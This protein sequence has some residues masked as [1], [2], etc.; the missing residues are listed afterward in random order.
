MRV[1]PF[2]ILLALLMACTYNPSYTGINCGPE[3]S[4]P[5]GY[6]C[7]QEHCYPEKDEP[8]D[9]VGP[10]G[11][12]GTDDAGADEIGAD[13]GG[14]GDDGGPG[15][16]G[17]GADEGGDTGCGGCPPGQYCDQ[18]AVPPECKRCEDPTHC[19][20]D[21]RPCA[22]GESCITR[23]GTFCC[24]PSCTEGNL[25]Q[26]VNC[27]GRDYVC[28]AFFGPLRYDW[29]AI[30]QDP[31]HWC[32]LSAEDGPILDD[33]RCYDSGN[34]QYYCPWDGI[35]SGGLCVHNPMVERTHSCGAA[36]GCEGDAQ[37]GYCR[38]HRKDGESCEFNFDCESF[39]CSQ[40]NNA[41]CIAYNAAQ[42]KI[43]T[44]L[45]WEAIVNLYTWIAKG[46]TDFHDIDQWTFQGDDHGTKCTGDANCDSGHC[47]HFGA[48]GEN[49]CEFDSCVNIPEAVDIKATYFC[50]TGN[51]TQHM[52]F[53]TN[54]NPVP[55]PDACD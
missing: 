43:H 41:I 54:Q 19:G 29:N 9:E 1:A 4:C 12:A 18:T 44:T 47:R 25:C 10:D 11:D 48:V 28:R 21:C 51:H 5:N 46:T 36:F 32:R 31:P 45:Y 8:V 13:D 39:C 17:G 50:K 52:T 35:C 49:R 34:L 24:F 42:C 3:E 53:V 40:D 38:M 2:I 23:G 26:L 27:G 55:P 33:L 14:A 20:V 15:D 37:S 6:V 16:D 22:A 7:I 30:D